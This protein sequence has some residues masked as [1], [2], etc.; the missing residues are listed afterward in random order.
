MIL[1][2]YGC[3]LSGEAK[4]QVLNV[5]QV[6]TVA[7]K[8]FRLF[9]SVNHI[10]NVVRIASSQS[11]VQDENMKLVLRYIDILEQTFWVNSFFYLVMFYI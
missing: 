10:S 11:N 5:Q 8:A 4:Q 7:R 2:F 1:D 6:L 9:K 3:Y